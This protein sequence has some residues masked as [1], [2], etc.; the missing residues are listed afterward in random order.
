MPEPKKTAYVPRTSSAGE[1]F[2]CGGCW[3]S[4]FLQNRSSALTLFSLATP[5]Q[6]SQLQSIVT[7]IIGPFGLF[8]F[9]K[10]SSNSRLTPT[11]FLR[12]LFFSILCTFSVIAT[13]IWMPFATISQVWPYLHIWMMNISLGEYA[14]KILRMTTRIYHMR[15]S[16]ES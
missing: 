4:I 1:C 6:L 5:S 7:V 2:F 15:V 3:K 11:L 10:F 9:S 16:P 8:F 13:H 12:I 14:C